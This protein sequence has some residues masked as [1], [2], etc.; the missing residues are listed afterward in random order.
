MEELSS[1]DRSLDC[2]DN[3]MRRRLY[4]RCTYILVMFN[5]YFNNLHIPSVSCQAQLSLLGHYERLLLLLLLSLLLLL[6]LSLLL[7]LLLCLLLLLL[8]S[9]DERLLLAQRPSRLLETGEPGGHGVPGGGR[10][11]RL[12]ISYIS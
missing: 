8:L 4:Y 5:K 11:T 12:Y 10:V 3:L 2:T 9:P 6:L 1:L 7:L